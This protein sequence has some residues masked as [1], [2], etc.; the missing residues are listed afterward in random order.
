[1]CKVVETYPD[2]K[3]VVR[4]VKVVMPP[5]SLD[6]GSKVY[7][8]GFAM[9]EVKRHVSNLIVIVPNDDEENAIGEDC[10]DDSQTTEQIRNMN[11]SAD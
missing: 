8:K 6:D 4:N 11:A 1:M 9:I 5:P 2:E 7:K 3:N 10:S